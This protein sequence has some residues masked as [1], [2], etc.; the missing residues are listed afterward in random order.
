[1]EQI[2]KLRV[3]WLCHFSNPLIREYLPL[4]KKRPLYH[5]IRKIFHRTPK[6]GRPNDFAP[7]V[8]NGL[9]EMK[10]RNDIEL[11]VISPMSELKGK[12]FEMELEG[13]YYHFYNPFYTFYLQYLMKNYDLWRRFQTSSRYV[14]KFIEKIQPDIINLIGA[15]NPY[16]SGAIL[17]VKLNSP[18]MVS[19]QTYFTNPDRLKFY[20]DIDK[21]VRWHIA[22]L[23]HQGF[24]YFGVY[25]R[26]HYDLLLHDNPNAVIFSF[27]WCSSALPEVKALNKEYDF[28]NFAVSLSSKKGFHDSIKALAIVKL[29]YPNVKL[30]LVGSSTPA[31]KNELAKLIESLDLKDNVEFTP[32][33]EKQQDMFQHI[34]KSRFAVLPCKM[35]ITSGTM[36]QS[37]YYGLPLVVY[38]TTGTPK[39]NRQKECVLISEMNNIESLS[40]NMLLLMENPEK[41]AQLQKNAKDYIVESRDNQKATDNL[42]ASYRAIIANY[43][44]GVAI[45]KE[46][47]FDTNKYPKYD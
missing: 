8:T 46:L 36:S 3:V 27:S 17:D 16:Y 40:E 5:L 12:T 10:K 30:N 24:T 42:I 29:K 45:P 21:S 15:E 1:M 25:G 33:F 41:A 2:N 31:V 38:K 44:K 4:K 13:V 39:F 28:V 11:H 18:I 47:L 22:N 26:M 34:Q 23:I 14:N 20:P 35:D 32:F 7:W 43:N 19:L 9:E 6:S 37:M